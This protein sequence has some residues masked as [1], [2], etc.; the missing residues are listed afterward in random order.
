MLF[1]PI[2]KQAFHLLL[3]LL[4]AYQSSSHPLLVVFFDELAGCASQSSSHPLL[5]VV[6]FVAVAVVFG[7][8][9]GSSSQSSHPDVAFDTFGAL[10]ALRAGCAGC[11]GLVSQSSHPS[12]AFFEAEVEIAA[13]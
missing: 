2:N 5:V 9:V 13:G 8:I 3:A 11:I 10:A 12:D 1:V 7:F 4:A 6:F